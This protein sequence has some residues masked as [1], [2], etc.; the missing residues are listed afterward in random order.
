MYAYTRSQTIKARGRKE[1]K[2]KECETRFLLKRRLSCVCPSRTTEERKK[3]TGYVS[4]SNGIHL[5][6]GEFL[7]TFDGHQN[8]HVLHLFSFSFSFIS[9]FLFFF[10]LFIDDHSLFISIGER[11]STFASNR[12]QKYKFD[13][14]F[15]LFITQGLIL[16]PTNVV[17][18]SLAFSN[19]SPE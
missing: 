15:V 19:D 2:E 12:D 13:L 5:Q 17:E 7:I 6:N 16:A 1:K 9:I 14:A 18:Q 10:F 4:R 3:E 8:S 11:F